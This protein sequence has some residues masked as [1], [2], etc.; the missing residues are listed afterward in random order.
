MEVGTNTF[1]WTEDECRDDDFSNSPTRVIVGESG[2]G[3]A[4]NAIYI[5]PSV[6]LRFIGFRVAVVLGT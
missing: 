1:E 3:G 4:A 2:G 5:R 6:S